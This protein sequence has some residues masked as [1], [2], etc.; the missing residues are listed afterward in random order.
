MRG[1]NEGVV[2][3]LRKFKGNSI[4]RLSKKKAAEYKGASRG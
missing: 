2:M 1:K 3:G 4:W